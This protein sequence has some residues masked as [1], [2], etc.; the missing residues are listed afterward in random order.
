MG[1]KASWDLSVLKPNPKKLILVVKELA[2]KDLEEL[3]AEGQ[4]KLASM[5]AGGVAVLHQQLE[6]LQLQQLMQVQRKKRKKSPK[7]RAM[8]TWDSDFS[9]K[10]PTSMYK[11]LNVLSLV[12]TK[13]KMKY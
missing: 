13:Y 1:S 4:T 2:G 10:K 11:N 12:Q 9:I 7:K 8:T 3:I 6:E 5:P